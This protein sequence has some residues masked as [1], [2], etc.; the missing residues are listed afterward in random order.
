MLEH[1]KMLQTLRVFFTAMIYKRV[2]CHNVAN[3][4]Q[5]LTSKRSGNVSFT[6][7]TCERASRQRG[8]HF[9]NILSS[10]NVAGAAWFQMFY[11][12]DLHMCLAIF[13]QHLHN[14]P[15]N[16]PLCRA[17]FSTLSEHKLLNNTAFCAIPVHH[18]CTSSLT[19]FLVSDISSDRLP[20]AT[21]HKSHV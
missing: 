13:A 17:Y 18:V 20:A 11:G 19:S 1:H 3:F 10:K 21:F 16:L 9:S 2:S 15:P 14:K 8:M 4:L 7:L 5:I 12:F 6:I